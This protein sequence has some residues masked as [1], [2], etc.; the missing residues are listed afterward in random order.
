MKTKSVGNGEGSLYYSTKLKCW[1][2]QY[3]F[4]GKRNSL[5]QRKN[6]STRDFKIRVTELKSSIN[7]G[8][9]V[10][11]SA[12]TFISILEKHIMQKYNDGLVSESTH[13]RDLATLNQLK[14]CCD[15]FVDKPIQNI[16]IEDIE[17][18]KIKMREYSNSV[19]QKIWIFIKRTFQ[20]A[21]SRKK[22]SF[23]IMLDDMLQ[24]PISKK[25]NKTIEALSIEEENKLVNILNNEEKNHKYKNIILLQLYTGMRIGEILALSKDCIDLEKNT[26]TVYRTLTKNLNSAVVMGNH[27]KTYKIKT[28]IDRGK[29]TF[30]MTANTLKIIKQILNEK[31]NNIYHLLFWN[32]IDST[33]VSPGEINSYLRRLNQKYNIVKN[34]SLHSHILRHTFI[35]RCIENNMNL[36]AV[37]GIVGH[38]KNSSITLDVYTSISNDFLNE[39]LKKIN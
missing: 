12:D 13:L 9:H 25:Q 30:P 19:I 8:T 4:N 22:I 3:F 24:R 32:Y 27:T 18:S 5:K 7:N 2:F 38:A 16:T 35:T 15:N 20:I 33:Y 14:K 34:K 31:N 1:I 23:N 37:Q 28:N 11:K 17:K 21:N 39:E 36:K 6:E 29:R 26:L 10:K